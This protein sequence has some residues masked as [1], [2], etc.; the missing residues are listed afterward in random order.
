[1]RTCCFLV[2]FFYVL[3]LNQGMMRVYPGELICCLTATYMQTVILLVIE[4][5][6]ESNL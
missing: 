2:I 4:I 6:A 5:Y 1:M 3:C